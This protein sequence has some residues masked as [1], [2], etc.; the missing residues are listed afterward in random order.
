MSEATN[1]IP[2]A[3]QSVESLDAAFKAIC[4]A[5]PTRINPVQVNKYDSGNQCVYE[6]EDG[7]HCVAGQLL[8]NH[9]LLT[10]EIIEH[11][12]IADHVG[13]YTLG[14]D[15]DVAWR[16]RQWQTAADTGTADVDRAAGTNP[17]AW[18]KVPAMIA[19]YDEAQSDKEHDD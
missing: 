15:R 12:N 19:A 18:G 11:N 7:N 17:I 2:A 13:R 1:E 8:F 5:D 6:D 9:G 14:F 4:E 3:F 10:A 16:M